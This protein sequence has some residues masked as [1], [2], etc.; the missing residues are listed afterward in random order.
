MSISSTAVFTAFLFYVEIHNFIGFVRLTSFIFLPKA[1][2]M[3][4]MNSPT[5]KHGRKVESQNKVKD[6]L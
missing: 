6:L 5:F 2:I 3:I 4:M 1:M